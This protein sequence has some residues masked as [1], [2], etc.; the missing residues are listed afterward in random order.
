MPWDE[1]HFMIA[2]IAKFADAQPVQSVREVI[3]D[4]E[5]FA[6][7]VA[8][9]R[10]Y[11]REDPNR[12]ERRVLNQRFQAFDDGNPSWRNDDEDDDSR[13]NRWDGEGRAG[14]GNQT[15]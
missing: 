1:R 8:R 12:F 3:G 10:A 14:G 5:A 2:S 7:A 6:Q 13:D 15:R 9:V 11:E 4:M